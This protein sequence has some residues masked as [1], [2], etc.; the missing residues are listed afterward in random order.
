MLSLFVCM[1]GFS[2]MALFGIQ[3]V[4]F[5]AQT[6]ELTP[7]DVTCARGDLSETVIISNISTYHCNIRHL[8]L[9]RSQVSILI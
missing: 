7:S 1:H 2:F 6:V 5:Q 4:I 9:F 8:M 3:C